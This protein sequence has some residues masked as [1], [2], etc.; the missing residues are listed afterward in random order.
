MTDLT[1]LANTAEISGRPPMKLFVV[2]TR[3]A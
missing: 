2:G 1:Q 3:I